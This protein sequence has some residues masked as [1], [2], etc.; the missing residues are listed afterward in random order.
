MRK[1]FFRVSA[2]VCATM[3]ALSFHVGAAGPGAAESQAGKGTAPVALEFRAMTEDGQPV[4]DLKPAEVSLKIDGRAREIR[5]LELVQA[6]QGAGGAAAP[7][8]PFST[9][10]AAGGAR[11][12]LIL[13]DEDS[14]APGREQQV[15]T[16]VGQLLDGVSSGDRVAV[17][18]VRPGGLSVPL[19][20][21]HAA[22]RT[23][24][25]S[26]VGQARI[27]DT[28]GDMV[29]RTK[30]S[31][32]VLQATFTSIASGAPA[33]VVFFSSGLSAPEAGTTARVGSGSALCLVNTTDFQEVGAAASAARV[34]FFVAQSVDGSAT[35]GMADMA[36]GLESLAGATGG[37]TVR[38]TGNTERAMSRIAREHSQYYVATFDADP[39]ERSGTARRV[40]LSVG[41]DR[42][43]VSVKPTLTLAKAETAVG[44]RDMLRTSKGYGDLP[45]RALAYVLR[46]P[47]IIDT[48]T[49]EPAPQPPPPQPTPGPVS[50]KIVTLFE[51]MDPAVPLASAMIGL[52]D[53]K[54]KLT[55]Q[56]TAQPA[57]LA[58][59]LVMAALTAPAGSYRLRVAATDASGRAGSTD[60]DLSAQLSAAPPLKLSGL[61][62]GI[63]QSGAFAPKLQF[64]AADQT[65]V[66]Y[67]EIY[68]VPKAGAVTV[69]LELADASGKSLA[70]A[71]T[72]IAA[73]SAED[74]RIAFGGFA[75]GPL[76]PGDY[77]VR[78]IV[79]LDG[80][81]VGRVSRTLRKVP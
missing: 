37:T 42:V 19:T 10:A 30:V 78:A 73:A 16:A 51:S 62:L 22:V 72:N 11:D 1:T 50:V 81:E 52:F 53:E 14:I 21:D 17:L 80:K 49:P 71:G 7:P 75:I 45:L 67:L 38:L 39:G 44:P 9:N 34:N 31:L 77:V 74:A 41:R 59:P 2:A 29:C 58:R 15:K 63:A 68:A 5:T 69:Q 24:V 66:G 23:A 79:S 61:T 40:E 64:G 25:G 35:S 4:L 18:R 27:S 36:A 43:K 47:V 54:G 70:A 12:T 33:T 13:I 6:R 48:P 76:A 20:A 65:A 26:F 60:Y 8:P 56:W 46:N 28:A 57:E 32:Q 55:R 3:A